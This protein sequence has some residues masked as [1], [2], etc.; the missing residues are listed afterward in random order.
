MVRVRGGL[1]HSE[2]RWLI[3]PPSRRFKFTHI[4][5]IRWE[6][7]ASAPA[8]ADLWPTVKLWFEAVPFVAAHN[9]AFD[10]SILKACCREAG[11]SPPALRTVCTVKLAREVFGIYPTKLPMVCSSLGIPL[12]HHEPLSDARACAEIVLAAS[13][14]LARAL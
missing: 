14:A 10:Q 11:I 1:I 8:F 7:V 3:R 9:M 5:G 13:K 6:D 12:E 4:H 2:Q